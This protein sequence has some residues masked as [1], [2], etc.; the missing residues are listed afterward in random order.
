MNKIHKAKQFLQK[1]LDC[2]Y[3]GVQ[4]TKD[5]VLEKHNLVT[6]TQICDQTL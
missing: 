3:K 6:E 4:D 5:P 1:A 2:G